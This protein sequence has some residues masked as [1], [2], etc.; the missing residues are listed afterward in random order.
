[1]LAIEGLWFHFYKDIIFL[2]DRTFF[3]GGTTRT[4]LGF[5]PGKCGEVSFPDVYKAV[6]GLKEFL[7]SSKTYNIGFA[8]IYPRGADPDSC[9]AD[10]SHSTCLAKPGQLLRTEP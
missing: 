9:G 5:Q 2:L 3:N 4:S 7:G 1:M 8:A 10:A 6:D